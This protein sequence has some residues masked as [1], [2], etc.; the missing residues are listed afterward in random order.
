MMMNAWA[1]SAYD[2]VSVLIEACQ[3]GTPITQMHVAGAIKNV[4]IVEEIRVAL[5]EEGAVKVLLL[6]MVSGTSIAQ[7]KLA[8]CPWILASDREDFRVSILELGGCA[9]SST[10]TSKTLK[11]EY[12]RAC[13]ASNICTFS[14]R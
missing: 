5:G 4:A 8:N 1:I 14:F 10:I 9:K 12:T 2:G 6:L 11:Q 7:E 3:S 13:F